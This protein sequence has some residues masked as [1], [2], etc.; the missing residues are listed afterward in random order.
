MYVCVYIYKESRYD[1][2][3]KLESRGN[4]NDTLFV[5]IRSLLY[6]IK[7]KKTRFNLIK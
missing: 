2:A 4:T 3:D 5:Y 1:Y 7:R 6:M